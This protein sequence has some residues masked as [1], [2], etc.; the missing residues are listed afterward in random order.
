MAVNATFYGAEMYAEQLGIFAAL[1]N[2][3][4]SIA[5]VPAKINAF[6]LPEAAEAAEA[7]EAGEA[8]EAADGNDEAG[9]ADT[10]D[11][12]D[13]NLVV[14]TN[15][16][17]KEEREKQDQELAVPRSAKMVVRPPTNE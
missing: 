6:L 2:F 13:V 8:S 16:E 10:E 15:A 4:H 5:M 14:F 11:T 12:V 9:N 17:T 1:D 3:V 7:G